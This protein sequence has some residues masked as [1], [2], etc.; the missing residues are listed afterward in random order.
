MEALKTFWD[1]CSWQEL[2][3]M[4]LGFVGLLGGIYAAVG[5]WMLRNAL[6]TPHSGTARHDRRRGE[7]N[8]DRHTDCEHT[9]RT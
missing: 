8:R 4:V 9:D 7:P 6:G 1:A 3:A 5:L 2:L